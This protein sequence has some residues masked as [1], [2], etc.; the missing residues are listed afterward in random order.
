MI[1]RAAKEIIGQPLH[2]SEES[3]RKALY[4]EIIVKSKKAFCGKAPERVKEDILSSLERIKEDEKVVAA[5][6][7]K[8]ATAEKKLEQR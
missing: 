7:T 2:L 5:L 6:E 8:L 1:D 3:L 4:P